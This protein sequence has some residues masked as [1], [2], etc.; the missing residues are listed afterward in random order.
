MYQPSS[1]I[2]TPS[3]LLMVLTLAITLTLA[4][5]LTLAI[6]LTLA[7]ALAHARQLDETAPSPI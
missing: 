7:L 1:L 3:Y 6:T 2:I 4:M 5:V